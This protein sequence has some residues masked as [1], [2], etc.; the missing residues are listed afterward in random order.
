MANDKHSVSSAKSVD[1]ND[2]QCTAEMVAPIGKAG[3]PSDSHSRSCNQQSLADVPTLN[4]DVHESVPA[5]YA[6]QVIGW[7]EHVVVFL[8]SAPRPTG[9][10]WVQA[11][12]E[13][14][15]FTITGPARNFGLRDVRT[16]EGWCQLHIT[17]DLVIQTDPLTVIPSTVEIATPANWAF[18]VSQLN[19]KEGFHKAEFPNDVHL[20]FQLAW[21]DSIAAKNKSVRSLVDDFEQAQEEKKEAERMERYWAQYPEKRRLQREKHYWDTVTRVPAW[22]AAKWP[23]SPILKGP[24]EIIGAS[25]VNQADSLRRNK[26]PLTQTKQTQLTQPQQ[27]SNSSVHPPELRNPRQVPGH[28]PVTTPT[29]EP[30]PYEKEIIAEQEAI[31]EYIRS[32]S[33]SCDSTC[34][35]TEDHDK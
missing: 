34:G 15:H 31:G 5:E 9:L 6:G 14:I 7:L 27:H 2:T 1:C 28:R 16:G 25:G 11:N 8:L 35:S 24:H 18:V 4:V 32:R 26:I 13:G 19:R 12:Y 30:T 10:D 22:Y 21:L 20:H 3:Q 33:H 17:P 23:D 29:P